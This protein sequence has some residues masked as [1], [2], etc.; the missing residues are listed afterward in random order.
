M[1]LRIEIYFLWTFSKY[2]V[3]FWKY[4]WLL[5]IFL[6]LIIQ[7]RTPC[8]FIDMLVQYLTLR[9]TAKFTS[10]FLRNMH[11]YMTVKSCIFCSNYSFQMI[12]ILLT[13]KVLVLIE[14]ILFSTYKNWLFEPNDGFFYVFSLLLHFFQDSPEKV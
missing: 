13:K 9:R 10:V 14:E 2:F 3:L 7:R 8:S 5:R 6:F 1:K 4:N 11:K 12:I